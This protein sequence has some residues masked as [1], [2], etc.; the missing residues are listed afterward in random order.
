MNLFDAVP[1]LEKMTVSD[2]Q[3]AFA[4]IQGESQQTVFTIQPKKDQAKK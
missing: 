2:L 3:H 4:S 1:V